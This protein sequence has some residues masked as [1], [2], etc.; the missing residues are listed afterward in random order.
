VSLTSTR[1]LAGALAG[2]F[3]FGLLMAWVKGNDAGLRDAIGNMSAPWLLLPFLVGAF[4]V[5][6]TLPGAALAGLAATVT[7]IAGFYL[8]D[9]VVL[10]LGPHPWLTDL[11]LTMRAG[12]FWA[13]RAIVSGP[14]FGALGFWWQR[15]RSLLAAGV[16]A[17]LFVL[18][19]FAWWLYGSVYLGG[20]PAY[21]VPAY[22]ALWLGEIA[23][24]LLGFELAL[25]CQKRPV[26]YGRQ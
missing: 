24:G 14:V 6:R 19:P 21:P 20:Q 12:V 25:R 15:R 18:E 26:G 3:L 9:S 2:A 8:A 1:R 5:A 7:A 10:D 22:P 23:A 16:V 11:A 13:E 4:G 17:A